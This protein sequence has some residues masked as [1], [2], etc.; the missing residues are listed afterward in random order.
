MLVKPGDVA[1]DIGANAGVYTKSLVEIVGEK[2]KVF[3]FDANN[4]CTDFLKS[5]FE[6]Y[7]NV[8]VFNVGIS[9][10]NS[11]NIPFYVPEVY[12]LFQE[13]AGGSLF[14]DMASDKSKE[15]TFIKLQTLDSF[16]D[17]FNRI[18][19]I[20]V[21][22][23]GAEYEFLE[24]AVNTIKKFRPII[25]IELVGDN[26]KLRQFMNFVSNID[27]N[28]KR[29][30]NDKLIDIEIDKCDDLNVFLIPKASI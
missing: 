29:L 24:G 8:L 15:T 14:E 20:K 23:E 1:I 3:A 12:G 26:D 4:F 10:I 2:G 27:Y 25:Q 17:N 18:D 11:D 30:L 16:I 28:I 22:I 13:T 19:F 5:K 6:K 7:N 9:N 21:D